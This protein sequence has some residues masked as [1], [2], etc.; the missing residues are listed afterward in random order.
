MV[1]E[2]LMKV[3]NRLGPA[4]LGNRDDMESF[5]GEATNQIARHN[6]PIS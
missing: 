6:A 2:V 4:C 5:S 3:M 1:V